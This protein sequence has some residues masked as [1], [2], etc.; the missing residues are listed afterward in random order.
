[1]EL[2]EKLCL[3]FKGM[4]TA[5]APYESTRQEL[6]E[7]FLPHKKAQSTKTDGEEGTE[8][9]WDST[10]SHA[11][12]L[13]AARMYGME[14]NPADDWLGIGFRDLRDGIIESDDFKK[15]ATKAAETLLDVLSNEETNAYTAHHQC[16]TDKVLFGMYCKYI[17]EDDES[18]LRAR[19]I[20]VH[21]VY[22]AEAANGIIDTVYRKYPMTARQVVQS[23]GADKAGKRVNDLMK[24]DKPEEPVE[25]LH[26]VYPREDITPDKAGNKAFPVASVYMVYNDKHILEE[27]G[28][29]EMPMSCPRWDTGSGESYGRGPAITALADVRML[30]AQTRSALIV[31]EK[32]ANPNLLLSDD[33]ALT[34][35]DPNNAPGGVLLYRDAAN[36]PSYL[37]APGDLKAIDLMRE[38]T[39]SS[40][41]Q[42]FMSNQLD[43]ADRPDMTATEAQIKH[44]DRMQQFGAVMGRSQSEGLTVE[45]NRMLAILMRKGVVDP[46]PEGYSLRNLRFFYRNPVA[47]A[48]KM[49]RAQSMRM[50]QELVAPLIGEGDPRGVMD[51]VNTDKFV[52]QAAD[53]AAL[54]PDLLN[55]KQAV[56]ERRGEKAQAQQAQNMLTTAGQAA[57]VAATA[58][59]ADM[60]KPN[61]LT[62]LVGG[63]A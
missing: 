35:P 42:L 22:V 19:A 30:Y 49:G 41:M 60:S 34:N 28:Y 52:A 33:D 29:H 4:E 31:A 62:A 38:R 10:P 1:M 63:A 57:D 58:S 7:L 44:A 14:M 56:E 54:D 13:M 55:S 46:L 11:L 2:A 12:T 17:E 9:I 27:S 21:E 16:T 53:I 15:W 36:K 40:I 59:K 20:P 26:C 23:W 39:I 5:R 8:R 37:V 3:R 43:D 45:V 61:A 25:I 47:Q 51:W 24:E 6:A 50:F 32:M 18:F 48:Q